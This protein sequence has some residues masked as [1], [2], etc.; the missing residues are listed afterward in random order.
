MPHDRRGPLPDRRRFLAGRPAADTAALR[1]PVF[2]ASKLGL[3]ASTKLTDTGP[4]RAGPRQTSS[5]LP[6]SAD[7]S[8]ASMRWAERR[9]SVKV[10]RPIGS[11]PA[12]AA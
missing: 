8:T 12:T 10:G 7:F 11:A 6:L 3:V 2:P 1:G 9:P 4:A 5:H